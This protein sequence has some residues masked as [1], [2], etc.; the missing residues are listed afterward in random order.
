M[1]AFR[2]AVVPAAGL[3]TRFLPTTKTV[4]K[5][6]LPV[7]DTPGHRAGRRRG[8]RGG[9][10]RA[11]DRHLARQGRGRGALRR[12]VRAGEDP[13]RPGQGE[14]RR[15]GPP[16]PRPDRRS[17]TV[18][19]AEPLGLG[20]AVGCAREAIGAR[21]AG[22]R[23][24]AARRPRAPGGCPLP[25]GRGA[26]PARRQRALRLRHPARGDLRLRRVRRQ[27]HRRRRRQAGPRHGREACRRRGAVHVRRGGPLP[28]RR[29]DLRRARPDH[30]GRGWRAAAHR[31][32]RSC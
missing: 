1:N 14:A 11:A 15:E 18:T 3:G 7:V 9:R 22:V 16:G 6:L 10:R 32:R 17:R 30:P 4:P 8:R 27:R 28:P 13:G 12:L 20:H 19:Q 26:R 23:R 31:R 21:R 25:H 29:R 5:E 2:S 24:A